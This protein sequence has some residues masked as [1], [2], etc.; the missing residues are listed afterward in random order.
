MLLNAERRQDDWFRDIVFD[1]CIC[2]AGPAGITLARKLAAK[3]WTVGLFE[4]G[5]VELESNAQELADGQNI[6][7]DYYTLDT[8]RLRGLG[9]TSGHWSGVTRPF[10]PHDFEP[11]P[12]H[13]L[14][15]WPINRS[16]LDPFADEAAEILN[17]AAW[18]KAPDLFDGAADTLI[19]VAF[20]DSVPVT[21]FGEKYREDLA[22]GSV[23]VYLNATLLDIE[24]DDSLTVV[25]GLVFRSYSSD[26][27]FTVRA[28]YTVLCFGGI[29]NARFLLNANRQIS[30]GIG[31]QND[32]VGRHFCEH[33]VFQV[34]SAVLQS[35]PQ[36]GYVL[37]YAPT[38]ETMLEKECLNFVL[39]IPSIEEGTM[40]RL[41][42]EAA[43]LTD[44]SRNIVQK[45][46]GRP[47]QCFDVGIWVGNEQSLNP[48]SRVVLSS[49]IDKFGQRKAALD[50]RFT[51]LDYHTMRTAVT[52]LGRQMALTNT[53]RTRIADWLQ[54]SKPTPPGVG[55]DKVAA[56][57]HMCTTRMSD[58]PREGVVDR[59]CQIHGMR[60]L[61][62]G[63][64]S[65]FGTGG[66]AHP[67]YTIVELSLRLA[68][69]L[70]QRLR[71]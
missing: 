16:D 59:D 19:P 33:P 27:T 68:E 26:A 3:G 1:V 47:I 55:H 45:V 49:E 36:H 14:S 32:L 52:E 2:G 5:D 17:L 67:T 58:N 9:G 46:M 57:H 22:K 42:R 38:R 54:A 40:R 56:I 10:D 43:C 51:D 7:L 61:Y 18:N 20:R 12:Y 21:R 60:N 31:N 23:R 25:S 15:G 34:G 65:V 29:E 24:L 53:G 41:A 28:R 63:G 44:F 8:V 30:A 71:S 37:H 4:S 62:I 11:H 64:S 35:V 6:G 48:D 66:Y 70:D 69:H 13:P 39:S 50:W